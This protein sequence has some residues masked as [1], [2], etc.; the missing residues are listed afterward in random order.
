MFYLWQNVGGRS[1]SPKSGLKAIKIVTTSY[2][3]S[4]G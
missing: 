4:E 3:S 1:S 2:M